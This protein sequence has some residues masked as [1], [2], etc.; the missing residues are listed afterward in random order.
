MTAKPTLARG[1]SANLVGG[2]MPMVVTL[3]VTP[4]YIHAI[5]LERFGVLSLVWLL[6]G[7][8][9]IFDLGF[10]RAVT[11]GV[12]K[13][14]TDDKRSGL[15]GTGLV[16]STGSGVLGAALALTIA[17]FFFRS[18]FEVSGNADAEVGHALPILVAILPL[19]TASSVLAG[20]LQGLQQFARLNIAQTGGMV[21][22]QVLPLI[23]AWTISVELPWLAVGAL[24]GRLAGLG[25]LAFYCV[26][27]SPAARR[28]QFR[29]AEIR[30]MLSFGGWVMLS[31]VVSQMMLTMDRFVIGA[32]LSVQA[33]AIYSIPYNIIIRATLIPY[34]WFSV[35]FPRFAAASDTEARDLLAFGSRVLMLVITP[36]TVGGLVILRP[37]L[38]V[39]IGRDIAAQAAPTGLMLMGGFWF[40]ALNFMPLAYFQA[41]S[42]A[43]VPA[44]AYLAEFVIFVPLLYVLIGQGGIVGASVAWTLRVV[45]DG[46]IQYGVARQIRAHLKN[47]ALGVPAVAIALSWEILGVETP[48]FYAGKVVI[49][50]GTC[51][52]VLLLL[53]NKEKHEALAFVRALRRKAI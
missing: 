7:Y 10:G 9:G 1:L 26:K 17:Y 37:F 43:N 44:L 20:Y 48:Y 8:L 11:S 19:V 6:L 52:Y 45:L 41:R 33:V 32:V 40:Y 25:L 42:R 46:L 38:E 2:L 50:L 36:V 5:G 34:S 47:L 27:G 14:E 35:L 53:T 49:L 51:C 30:S 31:S 39:W 22:F 29:P 12:A 13:A 24:L 3:A 4:F 21:L 28:M 16:L 18:V 23:I 15:L